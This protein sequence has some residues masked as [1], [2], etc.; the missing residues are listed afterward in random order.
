MNGYCGCLTRTLAG[1]W[2]Q[3]PHIPDLR[4]W[5]LRQQLP[6]IVEDTGV[7]DLFWIFSK[8]IMMATVRHCGV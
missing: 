1:E 6:H 8:A 4:E 7:S 2:K 5:F 3:V